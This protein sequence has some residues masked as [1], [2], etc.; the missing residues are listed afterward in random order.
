MN[1]LMMHKGKGFRLQAAGLRQLIYGNNLTGSPSTQ[2]PL[3]IDNK[4]CR[5]RPEACSQ[6]PEASY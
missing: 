3:I 4:A 2:I 5:Q 1:L 6:K